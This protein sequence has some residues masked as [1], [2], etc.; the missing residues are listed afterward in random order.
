MADFDLTTKQGEQ[1]SFNTPGLLHFEKVVDFSS[2]N[3]AAGDT[4]QLFDLPAGI[5]VIA[6]IV[7]VITVEGGTATVDLGVTGV[8]VNKYIDG[9]NINSTTTVVSGDAATPEPIALQNNG[10]YLA[11]AE[12][13]SLLANNAL[14]AA[15]IRVIIK[16]ID[17]RGQLPTA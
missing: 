14:N 2:Q 9:A 6:A 7:D 3:L 10:S 15:K 4:A 8:D 12:T 1:P 13:V 16:A 5:L 11:T 17:L